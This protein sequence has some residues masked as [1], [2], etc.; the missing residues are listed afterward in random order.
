M[1]RIHGSNEDFETCTQWLSDAGPKFMPIKYGWVVS[2][3]CGLPLSQKPGCKD[4]RP[5]FPSALSSADEGG[6][7][8]IKPPI[9]I[10]NELVVMPGDRELFIFN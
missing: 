2:E 1:E 10:M 5:P 4:S 3:E 6:G 9:P 8:G 7:W